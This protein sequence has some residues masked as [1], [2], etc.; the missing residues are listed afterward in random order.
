MASLLIA[1]EIQTG[2]GRFGHLSLAKEQS[3]QPDLLVL[4]K[5]LGGGLVPISAVLGRRDVLECLVAGSESE[6]FRRFFR[7]PPPQAAK[8]SA[9]R[10]VAV[11][12]T[13]RSRGRKAQRCRNLQQHD[14]AASSIVE[15]Q[16]ACC[17]IEF[18]SQA[19]PT[20]GVSPRPA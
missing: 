8:C 18:G 14:S 2:L 7:K 13:R 15:G 9:N 5:S 19:A 3:W 20:H 6:T 1:D 12:S 11:D 16:G 10:R 17:V 4:G